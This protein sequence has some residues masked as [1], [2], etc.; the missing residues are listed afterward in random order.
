[1]TKLCETNPI[2]KMPKMN[3][4][5]YMTNRYDNNSGLLTV[6]KQSQT[7]PNKANSNPKQTQFKA[8]SDPNKA[9]TNPIKP[10]LVR[11]SLGESGF[12]RHNCS[13]W[14]FLVGGYVFV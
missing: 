5:Y 6:E 7:N 13:R 8:N 10:N 9:K 2:P 11:R 4:N 14:A 12:K 3:L 1:M